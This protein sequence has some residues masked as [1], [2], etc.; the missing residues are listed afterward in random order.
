MKMNNYTYTLSELK[1]CKFS[2]E[3]YVNT[4]FTFKFINIHILFWDLLSIILF[5]YMFNERVLILF[6]REITRV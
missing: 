5:V 3:L 4:K 2:I 6:L 1:D